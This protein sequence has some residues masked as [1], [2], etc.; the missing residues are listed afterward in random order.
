VPA[1]VQPATVAAASSVDTG[2][3][4]FGLSNQPTDLTWMSGSGVPW[5][6]RYQYLAGGVNTPFGSGWKDWNSPAGQFATDYMNA[7]TTAPANYVP[8]FTYYQMCQSLPQSPGCA[9]NNGLQDFNVMQNATSMTAY[10]SDFKLLVQ[11]AGAYVK[12]VIIHVEPDLWGFMEQKAVALGQTTASG[13]PAKVKSSGFTD[14]RVNFSVFGDNVQSFACALL[15]L[16]DAYAPNALMAIHASLW[17]SGVD[18]ASNTNP[19]VNAATE[20]DSSAAFLNSSCL[21]GN[22][23]GGSTWDLVF[24]DPDDHDAGWWEATSGC[25]C[26]SASFTHWWDPTNT[27]FPNFT[28]YLAWVAEL[29]ARTSRPQ[30][31]WQVPVGNQYF[32]T[33]NNSCGHYQDTVAQYFLAHPS[34]LYMSGLIA[35]LFGAGNSCQ[36][37]N[38]D[39]KHDGV[40]NGLGAGTLDTATV[41]WCS[42]CNTHVSTSADDDGGFLRIFVGAYYITHH[43]GRRPPTQS[44]PGAAR[45]RSPAAPGAT[46]PPGAPPPPRLAQA[47]PSSS[48]VGG[49]DVALSSDP[50]PP[51]LTM[52]V[53]LRLRLMVR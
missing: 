2:Q 32:Q 37:N 10:F 25:H 40:T 53:L 4:E 31:A 43:V 22:P 26:T 33:M 6:F 45:A 28:R 39:A 1:I 27:V 50:V 19:A 41:A 42:A 47:W 30:V 8:V 29:K 34:A 24:N 3:L 38:T 36:A 12:P 9:S 18:I 20:A 44:S 51:D 46:L 17:G 5:K 15:E 52:Q 7:S 13:I 23:F 49:R 35:V 21:A 11:K 14:T 48:S 16:R